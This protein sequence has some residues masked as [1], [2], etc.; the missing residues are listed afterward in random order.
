M[1]HAMAMMAMAFLVLSVLSVLACGE[2]AGS[3]PQSAVIA[4]GDPPVTLPAARGGQDLVGRPMPALAFDRWVRG[5][6]AAPG[7]VTLYRW[8]TD[9]CPF[10]SA[11]LPA[12]ETLRRDY[13]PQGLAV[14]SVFHPKPPREVSDG[15]VTD[16]AAGFGYEGALTLD[17]D[18]SVLD[19]LYLS[20]G[21]RAATSAA[22]LVD[23]QGVIRFV[24]P[25]PE[26]HPSED[27]SEAVQDADYR[28][29]RAAIE[30]LLEES[31][32]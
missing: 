6:P 2:P 24:H 18:W 20:T 25:G 19:G 31:R 10:C 26:F 13:E 30:V 7:T 4:Q 1:L 28:L 14:V 3:D 32:R 16:A 22:F 29:L 27:P 9:T 21:R 12:V 5:E 15:F 23:A 17:S 8:W 11:S